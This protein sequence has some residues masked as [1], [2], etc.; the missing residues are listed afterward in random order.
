[1]NLRQALGAILRDQRVESSSTLREVSVQSGVSIA[2][3]SDVERGIKDPSSEMIEDLC[4]SLDIS[5]QEL[6]AS[7]ASLV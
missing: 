2:H 4:D 3:I 7:A 1:M 6:L 5:L